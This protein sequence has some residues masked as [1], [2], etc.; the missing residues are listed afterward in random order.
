MSKRTDHE[1][2]CGSLAERRLAAPTAVP[3]PMRA[4][5]PTRLTLNVGRARPRCKEDTVSTATM[6]PARLTDEQLGE[7]L[8][9]VKAAD[10]VELK[11]TIP[12]SSQRSTVA[13]LEM[14]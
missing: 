8:E 11:L 6:S 1:V 10:S 9:L 4:R 3:T 13:A 5:S 14:D 12:E 7:V 2:S